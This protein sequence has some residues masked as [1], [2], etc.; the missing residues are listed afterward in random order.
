MQIFYSTM[1]HIN[2]QIIIAINY[3]HMVTKY[4]CINTT[5]TTTIM[6]YQK[7]MAVQAI[8]NKWISLAKMLLKIIY[9]RQNH[10]DAIR[11]HI[12]AVYK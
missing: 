11:V 12:C 2:K 3:T 9:A 6:I 1:Q 8:T 5:T 4:L 10:S 7:K